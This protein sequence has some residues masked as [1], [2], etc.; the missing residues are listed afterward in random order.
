[1]FVLAFAEAGNNFGNYKEYN[2][3][4]L[5]RSVGVGAR[6]FMAAFGLLGFDYGYGLDTMPGS[7]DGKRGHFH[8]MIGQQLR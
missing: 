5:Y 8:F 6:V 7:T 1:V 4:Q 3:F 2:P